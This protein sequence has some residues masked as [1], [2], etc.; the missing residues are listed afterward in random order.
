M[1]ITGEKTVKW[2][3]EVDVVVV[4]YGSAGAVASIVGHDRGAEVLLVE[5]AEW[6]G[7]ISMLAG[8]LIKGASN[9]QQA[10]EYLRFLSGGRVEPELIKVFADGLTEI[11]SYLKEL[12]TVD[13]A[14]INKINKYADEPAGA[15]PFPG[16]DTFYIANV[17]EIPGF[18]G[19]PW[20]HTKPTRGGARLVKMLMDNVESRKIETWMSSPAKRL[21]IRD[22]TVLGIIIKRKQ[23]ELAVR[24]RRGIVLACGGFEQNQR[25]LVDFLQ[26]MPFYSVAPLTHS[27]DGIQMAQEAGAALWHMWHIHGGYGFKF[28]EYPIGFRQSTG[29]WRNPALKMRWIIVDKFGRRYMNEDHP[30]PNDTNYRPMELYD[31]DIPGYPRIPSYMLF[32]EA[33]R[34]AGKIAQV[35][36]YGDIYEWSEDNSAEVAKGWILKASSLQELGEAIHRMPQNEGKME[37]LALV[38]TVKEWNKCVDTGEDPLRR[39]ASTM[40][41]IN[42]PPFYAIPVWPMISNTQGGPVHNARQQ[43]LNSF[44]EPIPRLYTAGELGS[45]FGHLYEEAGNLGECI[46]SGRIAGSQVA[47]EESN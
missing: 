21:V 44:G 47:K 34:K 6:P 39:P 45:F 2:A 9:S 32:D 38:D 46:T 10:E 13:N 14:R 25:L 35:L 27:G 40:V 18:S 12:A 42:T 26:G 29:G 33:G 28:D 36:G 17:A 31:P 37:P 43:V 8:G 15:Y 16:R 3:K 22:G 19:F 5:K 41:H 23:Q 4:G 11:E 30:A 20:V 24:A 1:N 7:G